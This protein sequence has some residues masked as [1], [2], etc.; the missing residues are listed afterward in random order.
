MKS[1]E[2]RMVNMQPACMGEG[3]TTILVGYFVTFRYVTI[4]TTF[5]ER[6]R[7]CKYGRGLEPHALAGCHG[8]G[9]IL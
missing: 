9:L 3:Y 5:L 4:W 2:R 7:V 8:L 6:P 1:M